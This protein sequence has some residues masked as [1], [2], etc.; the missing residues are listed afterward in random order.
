[1]QQVHIRVI[2]FVHEGLFFVKKDKLKTRA[3]LKARKLP[4]STYNI[5]TGTYKSTS[6]LKE[7][8]APSAIFVKFANRI[9]LR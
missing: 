4:T 1:M 2:V 5:K 3:I 8:N 6:L 7:L 9:F